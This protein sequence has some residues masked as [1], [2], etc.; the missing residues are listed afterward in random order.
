MFVTYAPED[1]A[2]GDRQEWT[3]KPGR[4]RASEAQALQRQ[5]GEN[6]WDAFVLGVQLND[7]HARR[8]LLW[9]LMRREHPRLAFNDVP[10]FYADELTVKFDVAEL[11]PLLEQMEKSNLPEDKKQQAHAALDLAL[12][13]AMERESTAGEVSGK[14]S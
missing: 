4:V 8:V 6:N 1:P 2:D 12:T 13:E 7:V 5:F 3:F 9:H 10:D 14:A 11:T